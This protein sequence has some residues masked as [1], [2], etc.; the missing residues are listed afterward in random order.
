MV[1]NI[2]NDQASR[3]AQNMMLRGGTTRRPRLM[4]PTGTAGM[5]MR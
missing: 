4:R 1:S 2:I 3:H 5:K